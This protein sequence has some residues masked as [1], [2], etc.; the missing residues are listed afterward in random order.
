MEDRKEVLHARTSRE[1]R[2]RQPGR[3]QDRKEEETGRKTFLFS[4]FSSYFS[5]FLVPPFPSRSYGLMRCFSLLPSFPP[6]TVTSI[7]FFHPL[8][9]S[10]SKA[11][12]PGFLKCLLLLHL[13][14]LLFVRGLLPT[15]FASLSTSLN[16]SQKRLFKPRK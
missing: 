4:P 15:H 16:S 9:S 10:P 2:D 11:I 6:V 5:T 14:L 8:S 13:S 7:S 3:N 12:T 1:G